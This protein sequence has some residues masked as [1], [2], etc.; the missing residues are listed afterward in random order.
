MIRSSNSITDLEGA[1]ECIKEMI[2]RGPEAM[3]GA[4]SNIKGIAH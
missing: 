3:M 2:E 1:K 4:A